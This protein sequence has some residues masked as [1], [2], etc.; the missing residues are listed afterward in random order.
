MGIHELEAKILSGEA[1]VRRLPELLREPLELGGSKLFILAL[2][3]QT[4]ANGLDC[5]NACEIHIFCESSANDHAHETPPRN[6]AA[7][8]A[9]YFFAEAIE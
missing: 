6:E 7:H 4:I 8:A 5:R 1:R 2:L 3:D 9:I